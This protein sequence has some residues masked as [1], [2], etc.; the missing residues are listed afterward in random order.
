M[1][2]ELKDEKLVVEI[3]NLVN[4]CEKLEEDLDT[5]CEFMKG[6]FLSTSGLN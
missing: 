4:S 5:Y 3:T 6:M 1:F 2:N